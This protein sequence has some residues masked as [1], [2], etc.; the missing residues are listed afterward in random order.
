MSSTKAPA[1]DAGNAASPQRNASGTVSN[2]RRPASA[3]PKPDKPAS[4]KQP[5]VKPPAAKQADAKQPAT[6]PWLIVLVP[7]ERI[8]P[9]PYQP[10]MSFDADEMSELIASVR[11]KGVQQPI[12]V[13]T[14]KADQQS[15]QDQKLV[16]DAANGKPNGTKANG[17][18]LNGS[19]ANGYKTNGV[20]NP[21]LVRYEMIAG[22]R[23]LRACKEAG[24]RSIPAIIRD[25]LNDVECA[26]LALLENVQRSNLNVIE[27]AR[28]YKR[29]MLQFRMKEERI[30]KKVGKSVA[31]IREMLKLLTLPEA[32][33]K[34]LASKSLTPSH[35]QQLLR[36]APFET[37][38]VLVAHKAV[39]DHLTAFSLTE[40]LLPNARELKD[41]GMLME[42]DYKTQFDWK[43]EC[44][45]CPHKAYFQSGYNSYCLKPDEW[46]KK[47][48]AA[49]ELKKQEASR[50]LEEARQEGR[51]TVET[52]KLPPGTYRDLSYATVPSG[53]SA[54]CPCRGQA[55]DPRDATRKVPVCLDPKR[56]AELVQAE[57]DAHLDTRRQR[58]A[59]LWDDA[60]E[61]LRAEQQSGACYKIAALLTLPVLIGRHRSYSD[62]AA[63]EGLVR[64]VGQ[65]LSIFLDWETLLDFET[66]EAAT[67]AL[68]QEVEPDRLLLFAACL[69]L[70]QEASETVRYGGDTPCLHHVLGLEETHQPELA[71]E[72]GMEADDINP[73]EEEANEEEAND[74][75]V[76]VVDA[77]HDLSADEAEEPIDEPTREQATTT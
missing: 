31:T 56:F 67:L 3:T 14:C 48:E 19:K 54:Q 69:L 21:N 76:A 4:A 45:H 18:Q 6:G 27:E 77:G 13:R 55:G 26:E 7:V 38:C 46:R 12:M 16:P 59:T 57:W 17:V 47:Q 11:A 28:G 20:V 51:T 37:A 22:E 40:S 62:P 42:L 50:V 8:E 75:N 49:I 9:S 23:R 71:E 33:Q 24:R 30:A 43:D 36:L 34:L 65:E 15:L 41:K 1:P 63:W 73:A 74:A 10:R 39:H 35:G 70:A 5:A 32:V 61:V 64:Q 66:D 60:R 72:D 53:C 52:D 29:L 68:L 25:D 58:F 44:G 2:G